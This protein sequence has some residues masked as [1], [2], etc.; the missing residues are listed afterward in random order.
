MDMKIRLLSVP[1]LLALV[2]SLAA[3]GGSGQSVPAN[4]VADVN[5]TPI[6]TAQ[7]NDFFQQALANAKAHGSTVSPGT[8]DYTTLR[9]QTV[10]E[11]VALAE[12][13]AQM[14]KEGVTV[15]PSDV[16]AFI[17]NLVK[18]NYSGSRSKF[19]NA[20]KA[21]GLTDKAAKEQVEI[22]LISTRIHDKVIATAKVTPA[23]EQA[24]YNANK[25]TFVI[26]PATT[27]NIAHI[28]V[29]TKAQANMIEQKLSHGAKF[30]ALAKKYS[31]DTGSAQN[32]G[33]LCAAKS[34]TSGQCSQMVAPF[35]KAAFALRTGQISAPVHSQ[36]G[37]HVITAL[38]PIVHVKGHTQTLAEA[39]AGIDQTLL[40]QQQDKLW[41]Q[42]IADLQSQYKGKVSYQNGYAP[43]TTTALSTTG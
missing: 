35:A 36:F 31:T 21:A 11:L 26:A 28:L 27:R 41:Q 34:G 39:R 3:C 8:S 19:E 7:F 14:Q 25:T 24:Y 30:A 22:N 10:S 40:Q 29:K 37:W 12:L 4:A 9:D 43:Q 18:S 32:G 38:G 6:T 42:W 17:S 13:K 16:N 1:V 20:L 5:G 23:Q 2:A 33:K 15:T